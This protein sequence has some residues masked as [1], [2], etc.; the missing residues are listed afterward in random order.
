MILEL[1]IPLATGC[2]VIILVTVEI[3]L[4]M[5]VRALTKAIQKLNVETQDK[6]NILVDEI[7]KKFKS[8]IDLAVAF[9]K[10]KEGKK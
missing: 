3:F 5:A 6:F 10:V 2:M 9:N 8:L 1:A 7:S 4:I